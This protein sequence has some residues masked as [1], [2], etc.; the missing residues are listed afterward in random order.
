MRIITHKVPNKSLARWFAFGMLCGVIG[1]ACF[2]DRFP[3][4]PV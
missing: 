3:L 4:L 1:A 2:V